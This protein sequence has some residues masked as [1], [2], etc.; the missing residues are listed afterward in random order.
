MFDELEEIFDKM[1]YQK[2]EGIL[3]QLVIDSNTGKPNLLVYTFLWTKLIK[4]E[5]AT[6]HL[7]ASK[8][9][10]LTLNYTDKGEEIGLYHGLRASALEPD[11]IDILEYLLYFNHIPEKVLSDEMAVSFAKRIIIQKPDSLVAKMTLG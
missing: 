5:T 7:I 3:N 2:V 1:P 10:G 6:Y 9:M 8:I 4:R 11:N